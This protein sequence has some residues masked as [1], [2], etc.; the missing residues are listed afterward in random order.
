V[1]PLLFGDAEPG[2]RLPITFPEQENDLG[3]SPQQYPG[4]G[5]KVYYT[6]AGL[7]LFTTFLAGF[8]LSHTDT[9]FTTLLCSQRV[10]SL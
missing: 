6:E 1:N 8:V 3:M 7:A 2:G 10:F 9:L 5:D 4:E